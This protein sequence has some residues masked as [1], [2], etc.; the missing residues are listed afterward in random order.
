MINFI[1]YKDNG[2]PPSNTKILHFILSKSL[3]EVKES[4]YKLPQKKPQLWAIFLLKPEG[5]PSYRTI[6]L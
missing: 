5:Q 2:Y 6:V 1:F 4:V 3:N